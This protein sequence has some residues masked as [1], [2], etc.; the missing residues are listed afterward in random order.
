[1]MIIFFIYILKITLILGED[2][3]VINIIKYIFLILIINKYIY[4]I[5]IS[6]Y[7]YIY[8]YIYIYI[9]IFLIFF[10]NYLF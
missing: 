8:K 3:M 9:Y 1:M 2:E 7:K 5:Y 10:K 6:W 4:L